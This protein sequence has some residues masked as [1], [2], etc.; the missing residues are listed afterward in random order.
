MSF[1]QLTAK[2]QTAY[3]LGDVRHLLNACGLNTPRETNTIVLIGA[4]SFILAAAIAR[5]STGS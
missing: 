1:S 3:T 4:P 2:L 5:N